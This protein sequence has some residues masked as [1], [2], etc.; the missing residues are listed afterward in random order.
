MPVVAGNLSGRPPAVLR[1]PSD[2]VGRAAPSADPLLACLAYLAGTYGLP[3]SQAAILNHLPRGDN[4]LLTPQLFPRAAERLGLKART[5]TR[6]PSDVPGLLV[7]FIVLFANGD[8]GVVTQRT[9]S[10]IA[11]K[12][13][14][15][16]VFPAVSDSPRS[17]TTKKLNADALDVVIYVAPNEAMS[18]APT[19]EPFGVQRHWFWGEVRRYWPAWIQIVVAAFVLN[20]LG[21]AFPLFVM[22]IYDR[23]IPNLAIPTLW[24]LTAGILMTLLFEL[25]LRQLR[26]KALDEVGKRVDMRIAAKLFEHVLAISMKERRV[27]TGA[28][29]NQIREFET[30]RDFFTSS[31]VIAVTDLLFIGVFVFVL[32]VIVGPIAYVPMVAVPIVLAITLLIQLPLNRSVRVTSHEASRRHALLVESLAAVETVKAVGGEGMLQRRWE[33]A[34]S[35]NARAGTATRLWSSLA[36]YATAAVQQLVGIV[37]LVWGVFLVADGRITIGGLIAAHLLAGRSLAPLT[38]IAMT[39]ARAQQS[40]VAMRAITAL[41]QLSTDRSTVLHSAERVARGDVEF[42]AVHFR[43]P[44]SELEALSNVTM[45]IASGERV[46]I[47]GRVGSGKSTVGRLIAGLYP[48]NSGTVLIDDAEIRRYDPAE[49]RSEVG[50]VAQDA[51]LFAG[52]L[53]DNITLGHSRASEAEIAEAVR[54]AGVDSFTRAHPQGLSLRLGERGCGL[55]GG[56]RQAVA[57]ARMLLKEPKILFLDEPSSAMDANTEAELIRRIREWCARGTTLILCSHRS[58]FLELVDRLIVLDGGKVVADGPRDDILRRLGA[59]DAIARPA[60]AAS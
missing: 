50:F 60:A 29:A 59:A 27:D 48:A 42:R 4:G 10:R 34:V 19:G 18:A 13:R 46:G 47:L 25:L 7:P 11:G 57:L 51:E 49:L 38:N 52:T 2:A 15:Q 28:M 5:V 39:L 36:L 8:A 22:S 1:L 12:H 37:V 24:A 9:T 41:F 17:V 26:S 55:S 14:W 6:R 31:S 35:A 30:V 40:F 3:F 16:I 44:G 58:S 45:R 23:V 21:L 33:D 32:F 54:V 53:R 20:L 56:Q 43:Y